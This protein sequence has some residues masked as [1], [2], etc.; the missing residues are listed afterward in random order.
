MDEFSNLKLSFHKIV[1][2][3]QI[4]YSLKTK[5]KRE[6]LFC[7]GGKFKNE[8]I[9]GSLYFCEIDPKFLDTST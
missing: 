3:D 6:G 5:I 2:T 7:F 4:D 8:K 9:N 1:S